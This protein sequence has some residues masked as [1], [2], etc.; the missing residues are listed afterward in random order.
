[1]LFQEIIYNLISAYIFLYLCHSD[2]N[3]VYYNF[4]IVL[5][6]RG[7]TSLQEST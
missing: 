1:M 2:F 3:E 7:Y 4:N 5:Y 6:L